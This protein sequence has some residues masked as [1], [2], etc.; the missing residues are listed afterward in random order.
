MLSRRLLCV[1]IALPLFAAA[2]PSAAQGPTSVAILP[3][4]LSG[5]APPELAIS[6]WRSLRFGIERSGQKAVADRATARRLLRARIEARGAHYRVEIELLGGETRGRPRLRVMRQD[7]AVCTITELNRL[8]RQ[9]TRQ[10]LAETVPPQAPGQTL[11]LPASPSPQATALAPGREIP[12]A[13]PMPD[14]QPTISI[15][16]ADTPP[17]PRYRT[18]KWVTGGAA[19]AALAAGSWLLIKD[20]D[21]TCAAGAGRECPRVRDT[22]LAGMA[23]LSAGFGLAAVSAWMFFQESERGRLAAGAA[24]TPGGVSAALVGRF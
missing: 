2:R 15:L 1:A 23:S 19:V 9:L 17:S 8:L 18:W 10:L 21:P 12:S 14:A 13:A 6:L 11:A 5:D 3:V 7:C 20:G 24:A 4:E 22:G 16:A